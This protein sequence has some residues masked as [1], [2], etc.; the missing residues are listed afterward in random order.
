[1]RS[2]GP[3]IRWDKLLKQL[4]SEG[5]SV[6]E[7]KGAIEREPCKSVWGFLG[8]LANGWAEHM[9]GLAVESLLRV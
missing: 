3:Q 1:M 6:E 4:E 2:Q 5:L 7:K 8:S 9:Q